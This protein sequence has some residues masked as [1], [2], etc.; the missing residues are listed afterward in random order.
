MFP[1]PKATIRVHLQLPELS[2][3]FYFIMALVMELKATS[4]LYLINIL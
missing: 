1:F 2:V 4:D 3:L